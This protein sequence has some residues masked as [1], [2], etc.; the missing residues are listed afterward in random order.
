MDA[1]LL[2]PALLM[3]ATVGLLGALL[4]AGIGR[5]RRSTGEPP[6]ATRRWMLG[7]ALGVLGWL[8]L[9]GGL[10]ASGLLSDFTRTPPP[11][12]L[13]AALSGAL[14]LA[15]ALSPVGARLIA[16]A[17]LAWLVG[18]QAFRIV[19]E[20]A[21]AQLYHAGALPVQM[22]FEGRNFDIASGASALL[23]AVLAARGRLP[24]WGLLLWNLAGL[25]L[26]LN[27]V[28]I[29]ALSIPGPLR[30]FLN[31]P[32]NT[33]VAQLPFV[34]LPTFLVQGALLGHV[35]VFR[36]VWREMRAAGDRASTRSSVAP[37][38]RSG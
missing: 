23:V 7:A 18:F 8:A 16:G 27:I 36:L 9:T 30:V 5:A 6:S 1:A 29:A 32:A 2:P 3:V 4:V 13:L 17:G 26:L 22:T 11:M 25:A 21:L 31:E 19:V 28:V 14:T 33:I 24:R 10:A 37:S 34:W 12:L 20:I 15:L 35:L 38:S